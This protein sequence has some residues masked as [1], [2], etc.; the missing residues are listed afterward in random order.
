[1][2]RLKCALFIIAGLLAICP[3]VLA[4]DDT[5]HKITGYIAWQRMTPEVR[6]KVFNI[7]FAAPEDSDIGVLYPT[8][9]NRSQE[10]KK[11]EYFMLM[12]TWADLIRERHFK[13]RFEKYHHT[14]W[15]YDDTFWKW[16]KGKAVVVDK[17]DD[18]GQALTKLRDFDAVIRS[19]ASDADKAVAIAWLEHIIGDLHQPL[20][21]SARVT[22]SNPKGDQGGN[23]FFLT[24][25]GTPREQQENLHWFWDSIVRR[26]VPNLKDLCDAEYVDPIAQDI[27]SQY[28]YEK[29][30]DRLQLTK[31][32]AWTQESL[33]IAQTEVF[34]D[35]KWFEM[36]SEKYR[37]NALRIARERLA[38]AG[39]RMG[40]LFNAAFGSSAAT[41]PK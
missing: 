21:T 34:K 39:Y 29:L 41:A 28:P 5:A 11:R 30:K 31:F 22:N 17:P 12:T 18:G 27:M 15:H 9:G 3:S 35:L 32:D 13:V 26:T 24:P 19:N 36:P 4:W 6:E 23:L 8:Y 33:A 1:M 40:D 38:L 37:E 16:E 20:H 2:L 10:A 14:N 25:K 7:L